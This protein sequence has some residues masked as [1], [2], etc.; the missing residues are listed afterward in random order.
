MKFPDIDGQA[1]L[2]GRVIHEFS[3]GGL[4]GLF[5]H[6]VYLIAMLALSLHLNHGFQSAFQSLGVNHKKYTPS[7]KMI[8]TAYS[9]LVPAAFRCN[10]IN[11]LL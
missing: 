10:S 1:N 11:H 3:E 6:A 2:Y 4:E 9:I 5:H 8:G 7:I